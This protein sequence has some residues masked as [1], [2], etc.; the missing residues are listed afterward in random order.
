MLIPVSNQAH[1]EW[2]SLTGSL[3]LPDRLLHVADFQAT[4]YA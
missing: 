1:K 3:R 4:F 2:L